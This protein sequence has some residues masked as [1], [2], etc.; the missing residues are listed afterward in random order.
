MTAFLYYNV[1]LNVFLNKFDVVTVA[2]FPEKNTKIK[3][4]F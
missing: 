1:S 4:V 2:V 3:L